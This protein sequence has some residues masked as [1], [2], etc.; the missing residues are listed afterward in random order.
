MGRHYKIKA[1]AS[2][3]LLSG[4][5]RK[6]HEKY[7]VHAYETELEFQMAQCIQCR[8]KRQQKNKF[9]NK[10][11]GEKEKKVILFGRSYSIVL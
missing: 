3:T 11:A 10:S 2:S 5:H 9:L 6:S 1:I 8:K 4:R 7:S